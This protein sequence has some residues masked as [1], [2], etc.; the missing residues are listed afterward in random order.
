MP[1]SP[2][3][4]I[5]L[6]SLPLI[7]RIIGAL[8]RRCGFVEDD[9]PD[10]ASWVK[11]RLVEDDFAVI[12]N[13]RGESGIGTYL[14]V[15]VAMLARDYHL[16]QRG[17]WRPSA[18][19][20][21]EGAVAVRLESLIHRRGYRFAEAAELLRTSGETDL[22]DRHLAGLFARLP[23]REPMTPIADTL[24]AAAALDEDR[25]RLG[26]LVDQYLDA[27][28]AEDR[29]IVRMRFWEDMSVAD[30]GRGLNLDQ[31]PLYRRLDRLLATMRERLARDG[32]TSVQFHEFID[33]PAA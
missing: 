19:A 22:S 18:A 31:K 12:R 5:F 13:F 11:L 9:A 3:E 4:R 30:I 8:C 10:F 16:R 20:L 28:P 32:L 6:D 33:E 1:D 29:L 26:G 7:E 17:R 15:V 24:V 23:V 2:H 25:R 21:R 14:T 27:F